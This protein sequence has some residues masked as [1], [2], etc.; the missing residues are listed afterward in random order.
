MEMTGTVSV[1]PGNIIAIELSDDVEASHQM[2]LQIAKDL[3]RDSPK[4]FD[5]ATMEVVTPLP[6]YKKGT[7]ERWPP[8]AWHITIAQ[9]GDSAWVDEEGTPDVVTEAMRDKLTGRRMKLVVDVED[10]GYLEGHPTNDDAVRVV[11][12]VV[13]FQS[14]AIKQISRELR[15]EA[16][17]GP[18]ARGVPHVTVGGIRPIDGDLVGFRNRFCRVRPETGLPEEYRELAELQ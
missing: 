3:I 9:D 16:G 4:G 12:Y 5:R 18:W 13:L 17:L 14:E 8:V 6:P 1:K 15:E 10:W 2:A 11:F 7:K